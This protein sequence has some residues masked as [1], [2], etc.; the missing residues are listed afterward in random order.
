MALGDHRAHGARRRLA[1]AVAVI[2][3]VHAPAEVPAARAARAREVDLLHRVLAD[4]ADRQVA[5][6]AVEREAPR[7]AEPV[8]VDLAARAGAPRER[9]RRGNGVRPRPAPARVD[10]EDLPEH[11]AQALRVAVGTVL[12]AP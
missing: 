12:V 4:V 5:G 7:V 10:P 2:A 9:V 1:A 8:G 11:R 3:L 6:A